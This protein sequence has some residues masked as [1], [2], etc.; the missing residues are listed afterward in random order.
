M[1]DDTILEMR[2]IVKEFPGNRALNNIHFDLKRGEVHALLGENGAGKSTLIKVLGGI[3]QP[4]AGE[5][6]IDGQG[7]T[8][9]SVNQARNLGIGI[10]HQEI[11]L[12][13]ELSIM[14]NL[15][16]GREIVTGLG[17]KNIA[18]MKDK[19]REMLETIDL[20]IDVDTPVGKLS[21]A[22]QQMIE[23]AKAVSF[24]V[25]ILVMDEPTSSLSE[26]EVQTL[27]DIVRKLKRQ[28]VS[29][30]YISHRMA[31]LFAI[32]DRITVIRDGEYIGTRETSKTSN[33]ELVK[34]MVGRSL[35]Q[36]YVKDNLVKKEELLHVSNLN[37]AGVFHDVS[38][39]V[40]RG[41]I[42]GFAGLVGSGRSDIMAAIFGA[43]KFNTGEIFVNGQKVRF[44]SPSQAI[45]A[46]I[47]FVPEDRKKQGLVLSQSVSFNLTLASLD[48]YRKGVYIRED[49]RLED[50]DKYVN[51]L[52]I[53]TAT[54]DSA[55][56]SL[57]GGNQQKVVIGKW[58]ATR[59]KI[60]ILDEPTRGV[61]VG[62]RRDIYAAINEMAKSGLAIILVSSDLPEIINMADR[63]CVV[64]EGKI[65]KQI[66]GDDINQ[67]TIM[68]YA[69]GG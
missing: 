15:F 41:E 20:A 49:K 61:D 54:V 57:S 24:N 31:E 43:E 36:F 40:H 28:G 48:R 33:A 21:I 63:V 10:I 39:E 45:Q 7:V 26:D 27:F 30:I 22:Q 66:K 68:Q 3:H 67:E 8:I 65:V 23:I 50:V 34:M 42:L 55:A 35:E 4:N 9:G 47:A 1:V 29:I 46:G 11:V 25:K 5:I 59:P 18:R 19:A 37:K 64:R 32:S 56:D 44:S 16:L 17:L 51:S 53:K 38:F 69:T 52:R 60:L 58:L 12:V 62:A 2:D 6:L 14:E 13:P